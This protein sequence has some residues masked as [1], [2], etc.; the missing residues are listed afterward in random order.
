MRR[1]H[2]G[3]VISKSGIAA[4]LALVSFGASMGYA[5]AAPMTRVERGAQQPAKTTTGGRMGCSYQST[6]EAAGE[7]GAGENG[8]RGAQ[9]GTDGEGTLTVRSWPSWNMGSGYHE[10]PPA[11]KDLDVDHD[12]RISQQEAMAFAPLANDFL[13]VDGDT[14]RG[15]TLKQ[16]QHWVADQWRAGKK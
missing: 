6:H 13:Y 11:F 9:A 10:Q 15:I 12:G 16:Y 3:S 5:R 4:A 7:N 14:G 1:S 2:F 8:M